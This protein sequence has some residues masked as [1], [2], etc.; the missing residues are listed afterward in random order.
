MDGQK[1]NG[2]DEL[3]QEDFGR[4]GLS[5]LWQDRQPRLGSELPGMWPMTRDDLD[6]FAKEPDGTRRTLGHTIVAWWLGNWCT[7][8]KLHTHNQLRSLIE[9]ID[10]AVAKDPPE[11]PKP[12]PPQSPR[13]QPLPPKPED[14]DWPQPGDVAR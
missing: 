7:A 10:L 1:G 8:G 11:P 13:P 9:M 6:R 2:G 3:A 4:V 5:L 14:G 12:T